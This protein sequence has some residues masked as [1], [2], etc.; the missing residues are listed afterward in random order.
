[1]NKPKTIGILGGMGPE[2]TSYFFQL[3]VKNS[4]ARRDEDHIPTL[5]Y[6][7][8]QIPSRQE[9]IKNKNY[10][11]VVDSIKNSLNILIKAGADFL[12][13][14]C[15]TAHFFID[16]IEEKIPK[17]LIHI[18]QETASH[19]NKLKENNLNFSHDL[20]IGILATTGL[21]QTAIYDKY[22]SDVGIDLIYP[23]SKLQDHIHSIIFDVKAKIANLRLLDSARK[24]INNFR[25]ENS[26]DWI[27]LACTEL[28]VLFQNADL[29]EAH[30]FDPLNY[31]IKICIERAYA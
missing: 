15:N 10:K 26:L 9:A 24:L 22:F 16:Q 25:K 2:S 28:S 11:P 29:Q 4:P 6:S 7:N 5:I 14:P 27:I 3:L 30:L 20:K 18:I 1:M 31:I 21:V 19:F 23:S 17:P 12:V 8:T 13:T